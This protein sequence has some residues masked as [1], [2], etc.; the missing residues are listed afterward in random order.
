MGSRYIDLPYQW[1]RT[2]RQPDLKHK[3]LIQQVEATTVFVMVP[4]KVQIPI[5][6]DEIV[7]RKAEKVEL[8]TARC[9]RVDRQESQTLPL[10]VQQASILCAAVVNAE[11]SELAVHVEVQPPA[12]LSWFDIG[13]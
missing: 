1:L 4:A 7:V 3:R 6:R 11:A 13:Q 2:R 9:I 12:V 10:L 5:L 8:L